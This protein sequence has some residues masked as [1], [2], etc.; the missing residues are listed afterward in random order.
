M[1]AGTS[2][3]SPMG[4]ASSPVSPLAEYPPGG[5]SATTAVSAVVARP[6]T[7]T[8]ARTAAT[9]PSTMATATAMPF[10]PDTGVASGGAV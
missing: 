3:A 2:G 6:V 1:S 5:V 7:T 9:T 4:V 8:T 10:E